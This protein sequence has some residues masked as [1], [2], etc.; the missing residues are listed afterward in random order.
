MKFKL[1][2]IKE[3]WPYS[4][5]VNPGMLRTAKFYMPKRPAYFL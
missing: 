2:K 3:N 5:P 4:V 1:V